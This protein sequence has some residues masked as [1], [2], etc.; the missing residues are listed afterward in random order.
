MIKKYLHI[1]IGS[2]ILT[3]VYAD[4]I[5]KGI[6][7]NDDRKIITKPDADIRTEDIMIG[8]LTIATGD[9]AKTGKTK[10]CSGTLIGRNIV[11]TAAHCF[12]DDINN[13]IYTNLAFFEL[14]K[15]GTYTPVEPVKI[16]RVY[17]PQKYWDD[18]S[19]TRGKKNKISLNQVPYD[20]ALAILEDNIGYRF[21][22]N[23][24][25]F[26]DEAYE[27]NAAVLGYPGEKDGK[28]T[29][30]ECSSE[31]Y[32]KSDGIYLLECDLT[33][34]NSGG[35]VI[36]LNDGNVCGVASA[37][38]SYKNNSVRFTKETFNAIKKVYLDQN[39][40]DDDFFWSYD[41]Q[42]KNKYSLKLLNKCSDD[43]VVG[44]SVTRSSGTE[45]DY[46]YILSQGESI[47]VDKITDK[48]FYAYAKQRYGKGVWKGDYKFYNSEYKKYIPY[49]KKDMNLNA[50]M[51]EYIHSFSCN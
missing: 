25:K 44:Y 37:I 12:H 3:N 17:L 47:K 35:P 9:T 39:L 14:Q 31:E 18:Y 48:E 22:W 42:T 36:D 40:G 51:G 23:E 29:Y 38:N 10:N 33:Q 26:D 4:D 19:A 21:G 27:F 41:L 28:L 16:K 49:F 13:R 30:Q 2:L 11:L 5:R 8:K 32:Y 20:F 34:G 50:P 15:S 24:V 45:T 6:H 7:G 46:G 1:I 43:I